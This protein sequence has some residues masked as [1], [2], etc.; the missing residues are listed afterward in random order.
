MRNRHKTKD[1][2]SWERKIVLLLG[3]L[4][5]ATLLLFVVWA[6]VLFVDRARVDDC[7]DQGGTYDYETGECDVQSNDVIMDD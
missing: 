3:W 6:I 5:G 4:F 2:Q 1:E 7:S